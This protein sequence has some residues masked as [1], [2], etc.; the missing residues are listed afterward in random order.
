[1]LQNCEDCWYF[2]YDEELDTEICRMDLDQDEVY[3]I[4]ADR[5]GKCPYFRKGGEYYLERHQ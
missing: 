3:R 2:E 1:M 5:N 4:F